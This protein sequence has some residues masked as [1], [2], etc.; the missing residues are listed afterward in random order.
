MNVKDNFAWQHYQ[1][2]E[3]FF[4]FNARYHFFFLIWETYPIL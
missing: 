3:N 1:K 2:K 4:E